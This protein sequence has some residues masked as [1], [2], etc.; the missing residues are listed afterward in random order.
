MGIFLDDQGNIH[1]DADLTNP[2]SHNR[3]VA[4]SKPAEP[5]NKKDIS[6]T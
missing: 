6:P 5:T 4:G 1:I 2:N 3:L